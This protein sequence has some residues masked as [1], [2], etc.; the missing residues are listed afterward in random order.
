MS[1]SFQ[2][3]DR[4]MIPSMCAFANGV[5]EKFIEIRKAL[6]DYFESQIIIG[7]DKEN[8]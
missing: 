4:A 1:I 5:Y 7:K 3:S 8:V 2:Y 6:G